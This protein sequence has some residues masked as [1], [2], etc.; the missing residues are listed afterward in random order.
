VSQSRQA[1][2]AITTGEP[3]GIGPDVTLMLARRALDEGWATELLVLGDL[4][5]LQQRA[6]ALGIDIPLSAVDSTHLNT[7]VAPEAIRVLHHDMAVPCTPGQLDVRNA[8][9][10]LRL[11]DSATDACLQGHTAAMV[12][13]PIQKSV[14]CDAGHAGFQGHTEYLANRTGTPHVVM[15]L[16]SGDF[17]V[18]LATT[19][20]ALADVPRAITRD[21]L[22]R[23]LDILLDNLQQRFGCHQPCILVAGLNPHAGENGHLGR[24]E[25]DVIQP[26]LDQFRAAGHAIQGPLPADTLFQDKYLAHADAVLAMYHDQGLPVLKYASFGQGV[27]ITLGLPIIRTSVDH[28]TALDLAGTGQACPDSLLAAWDQACFMAKRQVASGSARRNRTGGA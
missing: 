25:I 10:V 16:A 18:A 23:T 2:I 5:M 12:T 6:S 11:L 14:I 21:S 7:P 9:Y 28:G 3:A 19:H 20:L 24:E 26:V 8:D 22:T 27:N 4:P 13:A 15:M 1:P 17:R